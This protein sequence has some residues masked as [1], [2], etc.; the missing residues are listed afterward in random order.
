METDLTTSGYLSYLPAVLQQGTFLGR[1]LLA[2][3]AILSGN[4]KAPEGYSKAMP[5]GLEQVLDDIAIYFTPMAAAATPADEAPWEFI[6]WL[7]QWVALSISDDWTENATREL[8]AR[9]IPLYRIR[10]TRAGIQGVLDIVV[11][12]T[13]VTEVHDD[14]RPHFFEVSLKVTERDPAELAK[15]ARLVRAILDQEKPAHTY[16]SLTIAYPGLQINNKPTV[17]AGNGPGVLVGVNTV[18]GTV[19]ASTTEIRTGTTSTP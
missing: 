8:L 9:S 4:V 13:T 17:N 5:L 14:A 3:E 16:Y 15:R 2:F 6:P 1:F 19:T 12:G 18:L 10:G 7:A 11:S